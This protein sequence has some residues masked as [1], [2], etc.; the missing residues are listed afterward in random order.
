MQA[1]E[2]D[3]ADCSYF[4]F[5]NPG[6]GGNLGRLMLEDEVTYPGHAGGEVRV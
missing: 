4:L 2:S 5:I 6:S 3:Q 1:Q